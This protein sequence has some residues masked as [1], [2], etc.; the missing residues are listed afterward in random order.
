MAAVSAA[1]EAGISAASPATT[2]ASARPT[3][4]DRPAKCPRA[5]AA[6]SSVSVG[7]IELLAEAERLA[8]AQIHRH[9]RRAGAG[10]RS[11]DGCVCCRRDIE[12]AVFGDDQ[13]L[14]ECRCGG[15]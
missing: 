3:A 11:N 14:W 4:A 10:I 2:T 5:A 8:Y 9:L 13:I 1:S 7:G 6:A 12:A 15:K